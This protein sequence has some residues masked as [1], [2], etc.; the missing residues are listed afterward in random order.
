MPKVLFIQS[1]EVEKALRAL[2]VVRETIF[3]KGLE[4]DYLADTVHPSPTEDSVTGLATFIPLGS[5]FMN[6]LSMLFR[7]TRT[8]YDSVVVLFSREGGYLKH[9]IM[10]FLILGRSV[11]IFNENNDCFFYTHGKYFSHLRWRWRTYV[12][13]GKNRWLRL[14]NDALKVIR[15]EGFRAFFTKSWNILSIRPGRIRVRLERKIGPLAFPAFD[16]PR[17]SI[18]IPVHNKVLYTMNCLASILRHTQD[19]SYEMIVVDDK[20]TDSTQKRLDEV[21]NIK[22]IRAEQ[23]RGFVES[24]N[25][26][27]EAARGEFIM[28][29]NNDTTVTPG[30]LL[31]L[32][33]TLDRDKLCGAVGAKLVYPDGRLQEA[34][35]IIWKDARGWNYGKFQDP[36]R[37][38]FN[39]MREVDYCSGAALMVRR[40]LFEKFGGFDR[41]F[42]PAYWEDT[43][44]C[45]SIRKLGYKV[46]YQ[47]ASVVIH[48]EG[49][50]AGKSTASGMKKHQDLNTPKF[51]DKWSGELAGQCEHKPD[52]VF[53]ARDRN[54]GKRI[55]V[56][57]HY[58]PTYDKDAGSFFM[59]SFLRALVSDGYR[60]VFW[61]ENLFRNEHYSSELQQMGIEVIYGSHSF[62]DYMKTHGRFFDCAVITRTHIAIHFVDTVRKC[63]P[64]VIY[65]AP[66]FEYLRLKRQFELEGGS[67]D[68]LEKRKGREFYLFA[69][70]D[71]V[72]TVNADE[73]EMIK[74]AVPDKEVVAIH[75]PI[76]RI[77]NMKTPFEERRDLLFVGSSHAP[78][79]DAM[80]FYANEIMPL[81]Q[82]QLPGIKIYVIGGNPDKKLRELKSE[83]VVLTGFVKDLL[84]YFEKC[85]IYCAPL[86]YGAGVKGKIIEAMSYGL[87]VV[88]T[89][90]GAE[91][92]GADNDEHMLIADEKERIVE[93]IL[94][95]Y[96]DKSLWKKLSWNSREYVAARF[97][98]DSF[99]EKVKG[100]ME[101]VNRE[102]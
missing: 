93:H 9:K 6:A 3:T 95:L 12:N 98:Q 101:I 29:L 86:R 58:V 36:E 32:T 75:H 35:G 96:N 37:P 87:P 19:V 89:P 15:N 73:A 57:D 71:V 67:P 90:V 97:S 61:P 81:L 74:Q 100:L 65:H 64:K 42:A 84:P 79:A 62:D 39:Y 24:C 16:D 7:L 69:N 66:D 41:R 88:T 34:G 60:V 14:S 18:V 55:L 68:E 20:S 40:D 72:T 94:K 13:S 5:G 59:Y 50:S 51:V 48:F 85:R 91:G 17:V 25:A 22:V 31:A 49:V 47:P 46:M 43:D 23:N 83:D 77:T 8:R 52:I 4:L 30:W 2:D 82:K 27:A 99:R 38:E 80:I 45:F 26:G 70:S 21:K 10:A 102:R 44:L 63:I 1:G 92:L 78:N 33:G 28:F 76:D 56:I 53:L 11:L 54:R